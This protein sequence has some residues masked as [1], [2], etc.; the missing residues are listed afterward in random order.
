MADVLVPIFLFLAI[1]AVFIIH[2][3]GRHRERMMMV[4]RGLSAEYIKAIYAKSIQRDPLASLK[5]GIL[6][7]FAGVA[8]MLGLVLENYLRLHMEGGITISILL[9]FVGTGLLLYYA[10]ASKKLSKIQ[11]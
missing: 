2:L 10:I 6:F 8:L 1:A 11:S 7:A 5:W 3:V 9:I 4:E